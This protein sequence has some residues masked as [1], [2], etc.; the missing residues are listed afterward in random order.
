V[1]W[2][3]RALPQEMEARARVLV[4]E[5]ARKAQWEALVKELNFVRGTRVR[6]GERYPEAMFLPPVLV[7]EEERERMF[8]FMRVGPNLVL[9]TLP[10]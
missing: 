7:T 2:T 5:D 4:L 10:D 8:N 3:D 9:R 1:G 6:M